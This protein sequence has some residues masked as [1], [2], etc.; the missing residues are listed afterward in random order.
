MRPLALIVA[1]ALLSCA[2]AP[3]PRTAPPGEAIPIHA[4]DVAQA[5]GVLLPVELA[6]HLA[7]A[8]LCCRECRA[9]LARRPQ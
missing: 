5:D 2:T 9:E 7:G 6:A 3:A 8:E 4:G 1:T